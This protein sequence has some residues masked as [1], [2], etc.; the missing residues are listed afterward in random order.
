[1]ILLL[2]AVKRRHQDVF[3]DRGVGEQVEA[4]EHEADVFVSKLRELVVVELHDVAAGEEEPARGRY[5]ETAHEVH[6]GGLPRSG[7]PHD[8]REFALIDPEV[9]ALEDVQDLVAHV[10]ALG[11]VFH[12]ADG[13]GHHFI[14]PFCGAWAS[15]ATGRMIFVASVSPSFAPER[16]SVRSSPRMPILR[17]SFSILFFPVTL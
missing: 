16:I 9:D 4:L 7:G 6:Q 2:L 17:I 11:D 14:A 3:Q 10:K 13:D 5:V 1:V 8:G 12:E 15:A